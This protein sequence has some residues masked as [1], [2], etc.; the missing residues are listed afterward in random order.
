MKK[1]II[2]SILLL[3]IFYNSSC[4]S[5]K[6]TSFIPFKESII[7]KF[8]AQPDL[9]TL[10]EGLQKA[11]LGD[12]KMEDLFPSTEYIFKEDGSFAMQRKGLGLDSKESGKWSIKD[13]NTLKLLTAKGSYL[14]SLK[15]TAEGLIY[16][17]DD[18]E[19]ESMDFI[20]HPIK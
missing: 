15:R 20:L 1:I 13:E 12:E 16:L 17:S 9:K 8:N 10:K 19:G 18:L 14:Y 2:F 4:R 5:E 11:N 7:G 6:K 3:S